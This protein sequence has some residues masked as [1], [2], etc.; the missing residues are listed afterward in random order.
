MVNWLLRKIRG[1]LCNAFEDFFTLMLM[2]DNEIVRLLLRRLFFY[3]KRMLSGCE[4]KGRRNELSGVGVGGDILLKPATW[5]TQL[6]VQLK[7]KNP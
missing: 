3:E 7:R 5:L 1:W 2:A 4:T 6:Y